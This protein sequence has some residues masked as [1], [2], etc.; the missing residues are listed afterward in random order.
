MQKIVEYAKHKLQQKIVSLLP[1]FQTLASSF[2]PNIISLQR[3]SG[4]PFHLARNPHYVN[5]FTSASKNLIPS[6][7]PP[8]YNALK[9]TL[10]RKEQT[11]IKRL[12]QPIKG[13]WRDKCINLVCDGWTEA[14]RRP[15]INFNFIYD[16]G[17]VFMKAVNCEKKYNDKFYVETL[18]KDVISEF[19]AQNV[20]QVIIDNALI[21]KVVGSLVETQHLRIFWTPCVVDYI[22]SFTR[23]IYDVLRIMDM[24][25]L[26]FHLVYEMW[27]EMIEK[28]KTNIYRHEGKKGDKRSIF[29]EVVYDILIDRWTKSST[30]LQCMVHSLNL[31]EVPNRLPPHKDA[32]ISEE[33]NKCL[34]RYFPFTEERKMAF[35]EFARFSRPL[36]YFWFILFTTR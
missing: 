34:R 23:P 35:Q 19:G 4:L 29:Y 33:M 6:Y 27:D 7:I 3:Y 11:N 16:N 21:C 28:V 12:L 32:E 2:G 36:D 30:P 10:L 13:M 20:V 15:L 24:D 8:G 31:N 9:T 1:S 25:R 18:I 14:Q 22:L 5:A 17:V 26:T